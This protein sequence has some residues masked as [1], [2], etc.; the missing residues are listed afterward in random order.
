MDSEHDDE[1]HLANL[2]FNGGQWTATISGITAATDHVLARVVQATYAYVNETWGPYDDSEVYYEVEFLIE[3]GQSP[4]DI[5]EPM[6]FVTSVY[7]P[8]EA[9]APYETLVLTTTGATATEV[10]QIRYGDP[11]V[12]STRLGLTLNDIVSLVPGLSVAGS[13]LATRAATDALTDIDSL[14]PDNLLS[15]FEAWPPASWKRIGLFA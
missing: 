13:R 7:D 1:V 10:H 6:T 12:N 5:A 9:D 8:L 2:A 3:P 11:T 15:V 14:T 4:L